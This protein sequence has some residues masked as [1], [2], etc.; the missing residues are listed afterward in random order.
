[1]MGDP[2]SWG[3]DKAAFT[4]VLARHGAEPLPDP[5]L[6]YPEWLKDL[7][8]SWAGD[9]G[10]ENGDQPAVATPVVMV[11][12]GHV[13]GGRRE[14]VDD[15]WDSVEASIVLDRSRFDAASLAG[16]EAFSHLDVVFVFDRVTP[17]EIESGGRHP[18]GRTDW[19]LVG[20]F[21]Q[22]AKNRPNRIGVSTCTVLG[23][24]GNRVAV[25]GLD[26]VDGTPVLDLKPHVPEMGP[27]GDV[28]RPDWMG[29]LMRDYW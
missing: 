19:P 24:E 17:G 13:V 1:M 7:R 4:E 26:A 27:R 14:V 11:P 2:R 20:I 29:E 28:R 8:S 9:A 21:A 18:R 15:E 6:S 16:L 25:R 23:V 12:V 10:A 3:D 5:P 22:R